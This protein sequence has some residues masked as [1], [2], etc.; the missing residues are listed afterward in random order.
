MGKV[1]VTIDGIQVYVPDTS[2]RPGGGEGNQ[3]SYSDSLLF[4][5]RERDRLLPY[6]S[7]GG[8]GN[9][10]AAGGLRLSGQ[11]R[12]GGAD[13]H[14]GAFEGQTKDPRI[15]SFQSSGKMSELYANEFLRAADSDGQDGRTF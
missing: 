11:G 10:C 3:Y 4:E 5:G 12:H 6:V 9:A 2:H 13:A 1:H 7:G 15:D 14:A 8:Q